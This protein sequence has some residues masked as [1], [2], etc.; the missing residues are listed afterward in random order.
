MSDAGWVERAE[1]ALRSKVSSDE[2]EVLLGHAPPLFDAVVV[3]ALTSAAISGACIAFLMH[4]DAGSAGS[5]DPIALF[6]IVVALVLAVRTLLL[7]NEIASRFSVASSRKDYALAIAPEGILYRST[8][9][10]VAIPREDVLD[11]V[12]P[13]DWRGRAGKRYSNVYIV[14]RP[15]VGRVYIAVPPVFDATA[16][17]FAE[18]LMRWR[19]PIESA[20]TD[21]APPDEVLRSRLFDEVAGG[22]RPPGVV[23]IRHGLSW[24]RK[25]PFATVLVGVAVLLA[26]ARLPALVRE[27]L[28]ASTPG[29]VVAC[30]MVVPFLWAILIRREIRPRKGIALVFTKDALLMRTRSGVLGVHF[31][32]VVR[33]SVETKSSWSLLEG[34]H[35][36]KRLVLARKTGGDIRY[37]EAYLGVPAEVAQSLVDAYRK[38]RIP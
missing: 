14:T 16:G 15:S 19:G 20:T 37:E 13:G 27:Q 23:V 9:G 12:E 34:Y 3:S 30:L 26:Y 5:L 33:A 22:A 17:A 4:R 1:A 32:D 10:D 8:A 24:L 38:R 31:R 2:I 6:L 28:G 29:L 18:R 7:G 35:G 11:V 25:G 36:S 21:E